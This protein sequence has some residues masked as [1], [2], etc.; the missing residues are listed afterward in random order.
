MDLFVRLFLIAVVKG[1]DDAFADGHAD[2]VAIVF[3]ETGGLGDAQTHLLRQIDALHLR[4]QRDFEVF[5]VCGHAPLAIF[6]GNAPQK[7][8][9]SVTQRKHTSQWRERCSAAAEFPDEQGVAS[10]CGMEPQESIVATCLRPHGHCFR[11]LVPRL[12]PPIWTFLCRVDVLS[13]GRGH[14]PACFA[15]DCENKGTLS[16]CVFTI[17]RKCSFCVGYG[18]R[19]LMKWLRPN[20]WVFGA[21]FGGNE[22]AGLA[23][24]WGHLSLRTLRESIGDGNSYVK[25]YIAYH[26][27]VEAVRHL[28][29]GRPGWAPWKRKHSESKGSIKS[30]G[31]GS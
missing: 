22:A 8:Q 3:A 27:R 6:E 16:T 24:V 12:E 29:L 31:R 10:G 26:G 18:P 14:P 28:G 23:R 17:F 13:E 7:P 20:P 30:Y 1:V 19:L 11:L 9:L 4:L 2:A 5:L 21:A 25:T 15:K